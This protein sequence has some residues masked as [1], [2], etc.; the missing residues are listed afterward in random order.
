[1]APLL[2]PGKAGIQGNGTWRQMH[3]IDHRYD[4]QIAAFY[5]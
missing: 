4:L 1:M 2:L 5:A 3:L